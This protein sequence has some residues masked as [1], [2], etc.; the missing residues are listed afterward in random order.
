[1]RFNFQIFSTVMT[2]KFCEAMCKIKR[3]KIKAD[4]LT[5]SI[6]SLP[7]EVMLSWCAENIF[8]EC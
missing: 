1:M 6:A 2:G 5:N 3:R 4:Q 7:R 8:N